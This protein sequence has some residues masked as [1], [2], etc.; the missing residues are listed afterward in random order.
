MQV[1][2]VK[3]F[4]PRPIKRP[5]RKVARRL[6]MTNRPA[7][8]SRLTY[9]LDGDDA[10]LDFRT[11][12][13]GH[14]LTRL[15][16]SNRETSFETSL[17][18][19][20]PSTDDEYHVRLSVTELVRA[21]S[22]PTG[23]LDFYLEWTP[24]NADPETGEL[25][26]VLRRLGRFVETTPIT[27]LQ[28]T[29]V[30]GHQV[31]LEVTVAGNLSLR[32]DDIQPPVPK[33]RV[34]KYRRTGEHTRME[35]SLVTFNKPVRSGVLIALGRQSQQRHELGLTVHPDEAA[36]VRDH[37]ALHYRVELDLDFA[38]LAELVDPIDEVVDLSMEFT[39]EGTDEVIIRRPGIPRGIRREHRLRSTPVD[40]AGR[41][42]L[43]VPYLTFRK[44]RL[45]YRIERFRSG[46]FGYLKRIT[47][48]SPV[49]TLAKPFTNIWLVGEVPYKAQDNGYQF[50]RHVREQHPERRAY[51]VIDADSPD[52]P[53]VAAL[54]NVVDR[55]SRRHMLYSL[56]ASRLVG[57]HHAEY[58]FAS[59]DRAVMRA[60]RGV[61]IFL[62]H[63]VTASKNVTLN[64]GRQTS[65]EKP[66]EQ[67]VAVSELEKKIIMEDYGYRDHQVPVT[68]FARFDQLFAGDVA[69]RRTVLVM[70]TWRDYLQRE[71][72]LLESDY[73]AN[74]HGFLTHP[75]LQAL[76]REHDMEIEFVL[77]PNMRMFAHHF[78]VPQVRLIPQGEADVQHLIKSSS[79]LITDF[80]SV[81]WDFSFLQRPVLY[82]QFDQQ[83]LVGGRAPHIDPHEL[84]P[85]PISTR[86]DALLDDLAQVFADESRMAPAYWDRAKTF[87]AH[88]DQNNCARIYDMV[89]RA[90]RPA[91][92]VERIRNSGLVQRQWKRFRKSSV[93][94]IWMRRM[95]HFGRLLPRKQT[96][97]FECD[98]GTHYGD[99]PRY[100]YERLLERDHGL[101]LVWASNT[102]MRLTDPAS[103]KIVRNS[104][105]YFWE[106]SRAQ[107]WISNQ[108]FR[109]EMTKPSGTR[110]L[111]TWHGT[112]LKRMQHDVPEMA[113]RDPDY[114]RKASLLT[115]YWD[116]LVSPSPYATRCFRSAFR[117]EGPI[118][119]QG[120]PRNDPFSWPDRDRR[121]DLAR[122][123]LGLSGDPRKVLL[124]A[125]TFRDDNRPGQH[126]KHNLELDVHRMCEEFGDE[127]V[128]VLR[129]HPLVRQGMPKNL[130]REDFLIDAAKYPDVSELLLISDALITDYSS[131]FFDYAALQRP[132]LFF[133]YDLENYRDQLRGFYLDFEQEAPGPLL[134]TNDEL[135]EALRGLD[136]VRTKYGPTVAEFARTYG[137]KD[138]GRASDRV[139]DAFFDH[140]NP[141]SDN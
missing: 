105:R 78:Q 121:R 118:L 135:F 106:L 20:E 22:D 44:H 127:Y 27:E 101:E 129:L 79:V 31:V 24:E 137:P 8:V 50:F 54:G 62:Q 77:H 110:F 11:R 116:A 26:P 131:I 9:A 139:L 47:R 140:T 64:Y 2:T 28:R 72:R 42:T 124:Y 13:Q 141:G 61:R 134:S 69:K 122:A 104:P 81:A 84:L 91:I 113:S 130:P 19:G 30:D 100:L 108:N 4:I 123:R 16:I 95:F 133:T 29:D 117:F 132:I 96:V 125:P 18:L 21:Q 120:Y 37:G 53:K 32:V 40:R 34:R 74:W 138:D 66:T 65:F 63:G 39:L 82:F 126:W 70:P 67:F 83:S 33:L 73:F 88:R 86:P 23:S 5:I 136:A 99:S 119:E 1:A 114:H 38:V 55:Y 36:T 6:G 41:T 57:S 35:F 48:L 97:L 87:I 17:P 59:R 94:F 14:R 75:R 68:G 3:K 92:A 56:L 93:Y 76:L 71:D 103:R 112:P 51:Y 15:V 45:A 7:Y 25:L 80:S 52:R 115:S 102:T 10:V 90:W 46:D 111:Q 128:L 89:E 109:P 49:L 58:L 12:R 60:T 43:F 85:G 107:Y 98:R